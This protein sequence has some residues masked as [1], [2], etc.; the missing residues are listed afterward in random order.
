[1]TVPMGNINC[2]ASSDHIFYFSPRDI[3]RVSSVL[4]GS[5]PSKRLCQTFPA[6]N[7]NAVMCEARVAA[8]R[9]SMACEALADG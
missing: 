7:V 2:S 4:A 9:Q 8:H 1:M 6:D 5:Q 3:V